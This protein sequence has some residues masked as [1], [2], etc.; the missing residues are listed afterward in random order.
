MLLHNILYCVL[1]LKIQKRNSKSFGKWLENFKKEKEKG[2][3]FTSSLSLSIFGLFGL[4]PARGPTGG[5][6]GAQLPYP[7]S[8]P[9]SNTRGPSFP[10][11]EPWA[12]PNVA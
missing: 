12:E 5:A 11:S 7:L 2:I 3:L 9:S 1:Y 6:G 10:R 4:A 8:Q